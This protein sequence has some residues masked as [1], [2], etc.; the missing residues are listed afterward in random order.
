M[1]TIAF[2]DIH[3]GEEQEAYRLVLECFNKLVAP[4]CNQEGIQEFTI[5][6][7]PDA[8]KERLAG[9]NLTL[10]ASENNRLVGVIEVR[11]GNH[12]CL[13][14]VRQEYHRRGVA[15]R[16][17]KLAI[18][19]CRLNGSKAAFFEVNSSPYAVIIYAKMGFVKTDG[20][21]MVK[22]SRFIPMRLKLA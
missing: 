9:G 20:E 3:P 21:K 22:G 7:R 6:V 17:L 16:L 10:V 12:I 11:S 13:L 15:S 1:D 4:D 19:Q 8:L 14:F 2:R 18:E 5:Y